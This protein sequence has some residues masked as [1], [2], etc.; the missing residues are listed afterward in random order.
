MPPNQPYYPTHPGLPTQG[1]MMYPGA[2]Q[3]PSQPLYNA[4]PGQP[5]QSMAYHPAQ[6]GAAPGAF[7]ADPNLAAQQQM[8]YSLPNG[9]MPQ[10]HHLPQAQP[11]GTATPTRSDGQ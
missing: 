1:Q 10:Y 8:M 7:Y 11:T 5:P 3:A 4:L 2:P 9:M 6:A